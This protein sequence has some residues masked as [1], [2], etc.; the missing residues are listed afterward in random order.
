MV[1]DINVDYYLLKE[2]LFSVITKNIQIINS[3][4][5]TI[6]SALCEHNKI[7][8]EIDEKEQNLNRQ[9]FI[10]FY[11]KK[12]KNLSSY[13]LDNGNLN[14]QT[15]SK[16]EKEGNIFNTNV[17]NSFVKHLL[18]E[19]EL[20]HE[21]N[22]FAI[23]IVSTLNFYIGS[24]YYYDCTVDV[25]EGLFESALL[26]YLCDKNS[27]CQKD[28]E[29]NSI[30]R[31]MKRLL[32]FKNINFQIQYAEIIL[33]DS[34][35]KFIQQEIEILIS[36]IGGIDFLRELFQKEIEPKYN[37]EIDR[38]VIHRDKRFIKKH[39][40]NRI[41][42]NYLMQLS[43]KH[44][45]NTKNVLLTN[46]GYHQI[47]VDII[48]ISSDYLSILNLQQH[49]VFEDLNFDIKNIPVYL[50][51][52]IIFETMFSPIQYRP[53]FIIRLIREVYATFFT[54]SSKIRYNSNEY[55]KFCEFI[56]S[57]KQI[58]KTYTLKEIENRTHIKRTSLLR[59]LKDVS[60]KFN[61]VNSNFDSFLSETN[62]KLYPLIEL[63]NGSYFLFS[64]YF[65]G[66]SLCE[67][68][69][70]KLLI[71][72]P[73]NFNKEKGFKFENMIKNLFI[74]KGIVFHQ[75][76]YSVDK[77]HV[78]ECDL[79]IENDKEIIFIEVKNQPLPETFETGDDVETLGCLGEGMIKAQIQ[80][81]RHI[82][83]LK[84]RG[85]LNLNTFDSKG[86]TCTYQLV[87]KGRRIICVSLCSQEYFFLT[88]KCF[89]QK[90]LESLIVATYHATEDEK[91]FKLNNLNKSRD[92]LEQII[93]D[94]Y[95][96][97]FDLQNVFYNTLFRSSQQLYTIL[98]VSNSLDDFIHNLTQPI[99]IIDGS[100][101]VYNQLLL[102]LKSND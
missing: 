96:D 32:R 53:D 75:G 16:L 49:S 101:D 69:Y 20:L 70:Q 46:L 61:E 92:K 72:Y 83:H 38:F 94:I 76:K 88:N 82:K 22:D 42:Y 18:L 47:F 81:L 89:S 78:Y 50:S 45:D 5:T 27:H 3:D 95:G 1:T 100:G 68:I 24:G 10:D 63:R 57:E 59:I 28:Y 21:D 80:C 98:K 90:I 93:S 64:S 97:D 12:C 65:N 17:L 7:K 87:E 34:S 8:N 91:Q 66:F 9:F 56:L 84:D 77:S 58:C 74:E 60:V 71:S 41:P 23:N 39:I 29:T 62:Y 52:N 44:L 67:A 30:I 48:Q 15:I 54:A 4:D 36:K 102:S 14:Y 79:V 55:I 86:N 6:L 33:D 43:I 26:L 2:T 13:S 73:N 37:V 19:K 11:V 51:K 35:H 25:L 85:F 99:Y 31:S 40:V